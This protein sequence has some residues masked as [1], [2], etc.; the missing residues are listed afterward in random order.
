MEINK[1]YYFDDNDHVRR[2]KTK[3]KQIIL[4]N[5][6]STKEEY[7]TKIKTRYN[8]KYNRLPCFFISQDGEVYQHYNVNYY[9]K[10]M[11]EHGMEKNSVTICLE[12]VGWLTK[13]MRGDKYLTWKGSVYEGEVIEVPWRNKRFWATYSDEQQVKLVELINYLCLEYD[14]IKDFIGSNVLV[15]KPN[16]YKG[17]INR[18]NY[19]KNYYD[20]SPAANFKKITNLINNENE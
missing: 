16:N 19:S 3:K 12:N 6:S 13:N 5:S 4:I 14:I 18:S 15:N 7:F 8:G 11:D 1:E 20:L 17:V 9:T 10:M 2:N